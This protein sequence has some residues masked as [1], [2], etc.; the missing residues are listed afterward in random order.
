M[1]QNLIPVT[2]MLNAQKLSSHNYLYSS[3]IILNKSFDLMLKK[4]PNGFAVAYV[5]NAEYNTYMLILLWT[6]CQ[7]WQ[8]S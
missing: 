8:Y 5:E 4:H 3:P 6:K 1:P 7:F 2:N